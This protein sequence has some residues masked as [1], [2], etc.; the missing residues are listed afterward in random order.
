MNFSKLS[1]LLSPLDMITLLD[2]IHIAVASA[3]SDQSVYVMERTSERCLAVSGLVDYV[4]ERSNKHKS[5]DANLPHLYAAKLATASLKL[6]SNMSAVKVPKYPRSMLQLRVALHSGASQGGVVGLQNI[7]LLQ[8]PH[9]H[10]FG[11][12]IDFTR[13]LASTGLPLQIR[14][15][16][17]CHQLLSSDRSFV[18]ERCPD[19]TAPNGHAIESY[20]LLDQNGLDVNL[21]S[22]FDALPLTEC[23]DIFIF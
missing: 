3:F 13:Y 21:P 18:F 7:S 5:A 15:S 16:S 2:K 9:Y 10:I 23:Q 19:F 20:W 22:Q 14:I 1:S 8:I 17:A 6:L 4:E 12:A 11:P